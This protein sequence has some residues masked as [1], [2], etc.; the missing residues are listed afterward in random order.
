M[1]KWKSDSGQVLIVTALSMTVLLGFVGF[2]TDVG[3]LLHSRR[4]LQTA[5]DAAALAAANE[6]LYEGTPSTVT[7]GMWNAASMDAGLNGFTPGSS[8][9][10][11]NT[12][13]GSTLSL[14][15]S[16]NIAISGF[17]SAGFVQAVATQD[18]PTMFMNL[19]GFH[20]MNVTATAIA[21][22]KLSSKPCINV[23]DQ[24]GYDPTDTVD[25]NGHS[26]IA[27]PNCSM[28][29]TG[30]VNESGSSSIDAQVL[31]SSTGSYPDEFSSL[32]VAYNQPTPNG[33]GGCTA[34]DGNPLNSYTHTMGCVYDMNVAANGSTTSCATATVC[35]ISG[36]LASNTVYYYDRNVALAQN[37][38][39]TGSGDT[40][41]LTGS[42]TIS[43]P[44]FDF[45]NGGI[46]ITP[47]EYGTTSCSFNPLCG[48]VFDAPTVGTTGG[49]TYSCR[50][51][52]GGNATN[53]GGI[54]FDFG[55]STTTLYG[56]MYA[57]G[58]QLFV[59]DQ[60]SSTT[61]Y[62][63]LTIGNICSQ[64]ATLTV[65]GYSPDSPAKRIGLVY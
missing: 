31:S 8:N 7:S 4:S 5:A 37:A 48:V 60:G 57:P 1:K 26:L 12:S 43:D 55:S 53:P 42:S 16:P 36:P 47:P 24:G 50:P 56:V 32:Q 63:D 23:P 6:A 19:F 29:V 38:S 61:L 62:N 30:V 46:N 2:A 49:G 20:S 52:Y 44:Y 18:T 21:S 34:P 13:T 14:I 9:G 64:S 15:L 11:E 27:T 17:N 28:T 59:Q 22:D 39:V 35:S 45:K 10:A 41:Y 3:V 65:N 40:I 58:M 25:L 33:S 54:Y 51:G